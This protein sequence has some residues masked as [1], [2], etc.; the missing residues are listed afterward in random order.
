LQELLQG[1]SN[2]ISLVETVGIGD[3]VGN[4]SSSQTSETK[5]WSPD[6]GTLL[7]PLIALAGVGV[8]VAVLIGK[9]NGLW[10]SPNF[11][12]APREDFNESLGPIQ[13]ET[14]SA[15]EDYSLMILK[16]RLAKGEITIEEYHRLKEAL[17]E[18]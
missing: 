17:K 9:K 10:F 4:A 2:K 16:N 5:P 12:S 18:S 3:L 6:F 11:K 15:E 14:D 7:Y 1:K 13:Q 8:I